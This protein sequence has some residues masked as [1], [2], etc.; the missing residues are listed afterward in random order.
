MRLAH[1]QGPAQRLPALLEGDA[2]LAPVAAQEL[3]GGPVEPGQL[4]R[5]GVPLPFGPVHGEHPRPAGA[6]RGRR[7]GVEVGVGC[8]VVG[9]TWAADKGGGRGEQHG[10]PGPVRGVG[11]QRAGRAQLRREHLGRR[12]LGLEVHQAHAGHA[13]GVQHPVDPPEAPVQIGQQLGDRGLVAR[14]QHHRVD[15]GTEV[16]EPAHQRDPLAHRVRQ[17][18]RL[19]PVPVRAVG[20]SGAPGQHQHRARRGGDRGRHGRA[21]PAESAGDQ[22]HAAVGERRVG[23]RDRGQRGVVQAPAPPG[24]RGQRRRRRVGRQFRQQRRDLA[25]RDP[26]RV[27]VDVEVTQR[28]IRLLVRQDAQRPEHGG[29]VRFDPVA[30]GDVEHAGGHDAQPRLRPGQVAQRLGEGQ[31]GEEVPCRPGRVDRVD[32]AELDQV[33]RLGAVAG[34]LGQQRAQVLA[35]ARTDH[36]APGPGRARLV[37]R[38]DHDRFAP[39]L[40]QRVGQ[41]LGQPRAIG[42]QHP[43]AGGRGRGGQRR[44]LTPARHGEPGA[45]VGAARAQT[46]LLRPVPAP[47]ERIG[48]QVGQAP[49][50]GRAG[51]PVHRDAV[52]PQPGGAAG[53][54]ERIAVPRHPG[55]RADRSRAR[56]TGRAEDLHGE[57]AGHARPRLHQQPAVGRAELL[58][59]L[60]EAHRAA[61]LAGPEAGVEGLLGGDRRAG[62]V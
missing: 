8:G 59:R 19:R 14:V 56:H 48:G 61:G 46:A 20:Q 9:L 60:G 47:L 11:E 36:A 40:G 37:R 49:G 2:D 45:D 26:R 41:G 24:P 44:Q 62:Q 12:L 5:P 10:E 50:A 55:E 7:G 31:Q 35:A 54:G 58:D 42:E 34:E 18:G 29:L 53:Q 17:R 13:R 27:E 43:A 1:G 57:A 38:L 21:D 16:L 30:A 23:G 22:V 51:A 39:A 15:P 25:G 3:G 28:Q 6:V 32:A 4:V 33:R 52:H